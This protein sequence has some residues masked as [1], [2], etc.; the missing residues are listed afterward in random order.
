G[1]EPGRHQQGGQEA[2]HGGGGGGQEGRQ[3]FH[4]AGHLV[5]LAGRPGPHAA[6][7]LRRGPVH[8]L[9]GGGRRGGGGHAAGR[10]APRR[11]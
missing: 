10:G 6:E 7:D 11:G 3:R 8:A 9:G 2:R 4:V 1:R 5:R